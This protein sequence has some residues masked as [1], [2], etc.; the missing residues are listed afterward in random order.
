MTHPGV[1]RGLG[2]VSRVWIHMDPLDLSR[3]QV[4]KLRNVVGLCSPLGHLA[5]LGLICVLE[6]GGVTH[7]EVLRGLGKESRV[8]ICIFGSLEVS[9]PQAEKYCWPLLPLANY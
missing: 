7:P 1:L 3:F 2:E 8:W 9:S 4:P 6:G 5:N